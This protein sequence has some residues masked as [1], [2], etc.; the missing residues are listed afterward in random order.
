MR[1]KCFAFEKSMEE[2]LHYCW[3][4]R[5]LPLEPLRTTDGKEVEM[6]NPGLHNR[7]AGPDFLDAKVKIDGVV[8]V[9][10]VELHTRASD[11]HRHGHDGNP[12][13]ENIILHVVA[14]DDET[15]RRPDG[16][17]IPQVLITI[18]D[19]VKRN[20]ESLLHDDVAPACR[21][22]LGSI[23]RL[24]VHCWLSALLVERMEM[25][26]KQI[27][28]RRTVLEGDW[29]DV[30]FVT[31]ARSFGFGKNGDA[32]EHWALSIPMSAVGKHKDSLMQV[33]AIFFGQAGLLEDDGL[34]DEYYVRLRNEYHYLRRKFGFAPI[35]PHEWK[36]M[37]MRPQNFPHVRIAQL[38]MLYYGQRLNLSRIL[39]VKDVEAVMGLLDTHV[40]DYWTTHY[41]FGKESARRNEKRLSDSSKRLLIINAV[42]PIAFC[43][44]RYKGS[45]QMAEAG[46]ELL[47]HMRP[48][49][50][51][52][53]RNWQAAG[54]M[55]E[56]AADSQALIHLYRQYCS[57]RDCL[58]CRFGYEYLRQ[59][60]DF[61]REVEDCKG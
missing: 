44:G 11:W 6:L 46:L 5:I 19:Y 47:E 43:Y 26:T 59:T 42:A 3:K 53:V 28:E 25:R 21:K 20:Y 14:E 56:N 38:A 1:T 34:T 60:P 29:E 36:F 16:K 17:G 35:D 10:N 49:N 27:T 50:N 22:V 39:N 7:D 30:F 23:G 57:R 48:E 40:S 58:R 51:F 15:V 52:I 31:L 24:Q 13:Y 2:L 45:E 33:E 61:L 8:W 41:T 37:R 9:G 55:P 54:L 18:P 32:F 12:A 4:H